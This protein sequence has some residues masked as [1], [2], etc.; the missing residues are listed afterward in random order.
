MTTALET[1]AKSLS[2]QPIEVETGRW[3]LAVDFDGTLAETDPNA[4]FRI[5]RPVKGAVEAMWQ[6]RDLGATLIIWTCR[7][8]RMLTDSRRWLADQDIPFDAVNANPWYEQ[9]GR[10]AFYHFLIDDRSNFDGDWPGMVEIVRARMQRDGVRPGDEGHVPVQASGANVAD[11][12]T[13]QAHQH[14]TVAA[15]RLHAA[16][17]LSHTE[18]LAVTDS[19]GQAL[20]RFRAHL[21]V[22]QPTIANRA[23]PE[24]TALELS[25]A[26]EEAD[27]AKGGG[28]R[29]KGKNALKPSKKNP[30]VKRWQKTG[31]D[32][33]AQPEQGPGAD[34]TESGQGR[35]PSQAPRATA[36]ERELRELKR[37]AD[38]AKSWGQRLDWERIK[39]HATSEDVRRLMDAGR[40]AAQ[41]AE[42]EQ[43]Q[44]AG[45]GQADQKA[46]N[47]HDLHDRIEAL[48]D[49]VLGRHE[50]VPH[51]Q[52]GESTPEAEPGK[53]ASPD[54]QEGDRPD[55]SGAEAPEP[56][57][58]KE[59][60]AESEADAK[61]RKRAEGKAHVEAANAKLRAR[62]QKLTEAV[63][64]APVARLSVPDGRNFYVHPS[65]YGEGQWQVSM[66]TANGQPAGHSLY[67]SKQEAL[68]ELAL[69]HDDVQVE[70]TVGGGQPQ[71]TQQETPETKGQGDA[72]AAVGGNDSQPA[73]EGGGDVA[74]AGPGPG[75]E[76]AEHGGP[77]GDDRPLRMDGQLGK[78]VDQAMDAELEGGDERDTKQQPKPQDEE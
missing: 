15:D 76:P 70:E 26:F 75:A 33:K 9:G 39:A 14:I 72:E 51:D 68:E 61:A 31:Q 13:S 49:H 17:H 59:A 54:K 40:Q 29:D 12:L 60:P 43:N 47:V 19:T 22:K 8:G 27:L 50:I 45:I 58:G 55:A 32:D 57:S 18:R 7:S 36:S 78:L 35:Q 42:A 28:P 77:E 46:P 63:G 10:K 38:Q 66:M 2:A 56:E 20:R 23:I 3:F 65:T 52:G 69:T 41:T 48:E 6:L 62:Q 34:T 21:I 11:F 25:K 44:P 30:G 74:E 37:L 64:E 73:A 1:L 5:V 16:G 53:A 24:R 71:Q 4:G 67:P